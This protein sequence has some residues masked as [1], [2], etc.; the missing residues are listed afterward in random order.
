MKTYSEMLESQENV[1]KNLETMLAKYKDKEEPKG[2]RYHLKKP[3]VVMSHMSLLAWVV[4]GVMA[5]VL[6]V[7][8]G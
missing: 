2:I 6:I 7:L 4:I 5:S 1:S 3:F 8:K